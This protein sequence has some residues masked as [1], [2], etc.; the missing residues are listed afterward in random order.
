MPK[1]PFLSALCGLPS[2]CSS[3]DSSADAERGSPLRPEGRRTN[4]TTMLPL[5]TFATSM[6]SDGSPSEWETHFAKRARK[7]AMSLAMLAKSLPWSTIQLRAGAVGLGRSALS[8]SPVPAWASTFL[9]PVAGREGASWSSLLSQARCDGSLRR[10]C[11]ET[12]SPPANRS[13]LTVLPSTLAFS[14]ALA[15]RAS[16]AAC[17]PATGAAAQLSEGGAMTPSGGGPTSGRAL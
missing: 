13:L 8:L 7:L 14:L 16:A 5:A 3:N 15:L 2:C 17:A 9:A 6:Q 12:C 1:A 11:W 10:D 4:S